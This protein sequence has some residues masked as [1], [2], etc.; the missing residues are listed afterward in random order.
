[1]AESRGAQYLG[2]DVGGTSIKAGLVIGAGLVLSVKTAES[3]VGAASEHILADIELARD[4]LR[5]N[6]WTSAGQV[7]IHDA[8]GSHSA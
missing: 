2:L 1:M 3:H 4:S 6:L 5:S 7:T 8:R